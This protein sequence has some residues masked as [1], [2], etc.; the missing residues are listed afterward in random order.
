MAD[1]NNGLDDNN[2][3]N[4]PAGV[5]SDPA[6]IDP[7]SGELNS[8]TGLTTTDDSSVVVQLD[9]VELQ[10]TDVC[11]A[12]DLAPLMSVGLVLVLALAAL[13]VTRFRKKD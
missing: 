10:V 5:L 3:D 12:L 11:T 1:T 9:G 2:T 13:L 7:N 6:T 8:S 4:T